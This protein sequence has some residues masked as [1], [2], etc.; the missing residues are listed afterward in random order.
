[1]VYM[2]DDNKNLSGLKVMKY[3]S[4]LSLDLDVG[5]SA[6]VTDV[7]FD[8]NQSSSFYL[9]VANPGD[10]LLVKFIM[11]NSMWTRIDFNFTGWHYTPAYMYHVNPVGIGSEQ[12]LPL[13]RLV[14]LE[15]L[16]DGNVRAFGFGNTGFHI[17]RL[18]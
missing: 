6:V 14:Q 7:M 11:L 12:N 3:S 18:Y 1:M 5:Q 13:Y 16:D 17:T 4:D 15:K 9:N 8:S 10:Y 2:V